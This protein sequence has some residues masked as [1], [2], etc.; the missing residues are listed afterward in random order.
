MG[1][2]V[3]VGVVVGVPVSVGATVPSV[4]VTVPVVVVVSVP[5]TVGGVTVPVAVTV[6]VPVSVPVSYGPTGT[7]STQ[8]PLLFELDEWWLL[9]DMAAAQAIA[10]KKTM[11]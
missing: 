5:V 9:V 2:P 10:A 4:G 11:M 6:S 3:G 7:P 1:V 8:A